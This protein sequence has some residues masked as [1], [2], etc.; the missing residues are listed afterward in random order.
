MYKPTARLAAILTL[1]LLLSLTMAQGARAQTYPPPVGSLSVES[2]T[3]ATTVGATA[4]ITATVLDNAGDPIEGAEVLFI[5]ASQPGDDAQW[6]NSETEIT[7]E[8]NADGVATAVLSVGST[9]GTIIVETVS[10][11]QTS[12]VTITVAGQPETGG[13]PPLAS[14]GDGWSTWQ[15]ALV[16]IGVMAIV[17]GITIV[18]RRRRA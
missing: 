4:D 5:I 8:T 3:T 11:E 12:Q 7:V 1:A 6:S 14:G 15:V 18:A 9:P 10:G 2:S 17:G 13:A 16:A